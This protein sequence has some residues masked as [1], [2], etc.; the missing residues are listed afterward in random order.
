MVGRHS[1]WWGG[2][3]SEG[4]WCCRSPRLVCGVP[5]SFVWWS[6]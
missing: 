5:L 3:V 6:C 4:R 2:M 1:G